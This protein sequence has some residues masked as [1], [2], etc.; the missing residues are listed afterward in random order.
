MQLLAKKVAC[1]CRAGP[2]VGGGHVTRCLALLREIEEQGARCIFICDQNTHEFID[3]F[4]ECSKES[5]YFDVLEENK[6]SLEGDRFDICILD[7]PLASK[8][9]IFQIRQCCRLLVIISDKP[10]R[11]DDVDILIDQ[12]LGRS[13]EDYIGQIPSSSRLLVGAQFAMIS[14]KFLKKRQNKINRTRKSLRRIFVSMGAS[15][16]PTLE[17]QIVLAIARSDFCG[18]V[19]FLAWGASKD[20]LE[21][22]RKKLEQHCSNV[23]VISETNQI[24]EYL[25]WCDLVIGAGGMSSWERCAMSAPSIVTVIADNQLDNAMSLKAFGAALVFDWREVRKISDLSESINYLLNSNNALKNLSTCAGEI[26]DGLGAHRVMRECS[27][28]IGKALWEK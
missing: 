6:F 22:I 3:K 16:T 28:S 8:D 18:D 15:F 2:S 21:E 1:F 19:G 24:E 26:I 17:D 25:E 12:T 27:R 14:R 13:A 5:K 10:Q 9:K 11:F 20:R 4:E 23:E 7:D